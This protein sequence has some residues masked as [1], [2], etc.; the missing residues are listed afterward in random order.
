MIYS[1]SKRM[2]LV[3][4]K[5]NLNVFHDEVIHIPACMKRIKEYNSPTRFCKGV[6]VRDH[7]KLPDKLN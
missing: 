2:D 5:F 7:L 4:K 3:N 1:S 6:P